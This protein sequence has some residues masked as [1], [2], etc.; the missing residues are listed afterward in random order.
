VPGGSL[1][2]DVI[3]G[4]P[5]ETERDFKETLAVMRAA[6]PDNAFTFKYSA[7]PSGKGVRAP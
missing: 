2:T 1:T 4:F 6:E 7:A 5:A 3:A